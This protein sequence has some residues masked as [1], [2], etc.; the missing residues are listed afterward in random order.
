MRGEVFKL[1]FHLA[2]RPAID[3]RTALGA[4]TE[5]LWLPAI[6]KFMLAHVLFIFDNLVL[7]GFGS[8]RLTGQIREIDRSSG[9]T[10]LRL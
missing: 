6:R 7:R 10:G 9:L 2:R 3:D 5:L 4:Q 8:S 1:G